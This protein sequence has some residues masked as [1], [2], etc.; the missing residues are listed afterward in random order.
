[1][2]QYF[3]RI[4]TLAVILCYT[5]FSLHAAQ[6]SDINPKLLIDPANNQFNLYINNQTGKTLYCAITTSPKATQSLATVVINNKESSNPITLTKAK[7]LARISKTT[8][9]VA[10]LDEHFIVEKQSNTIDPNVKLFSTKLP[11][12]LSTNCAGTLFIT[13]QKTYHEGLSF[14]IDDSHVQCGSFSATRKKLRSVKSADTLNKPIAPPTNQ[15]VQEAAQKE[16]NKVAQKAVQQA[17]QKREKF[18]ALER[19]VN[20]PTKYSVA[21]RRVMKVLKLPVW[22][23]YED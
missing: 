12:Y 20:D 14:S 19:D 15:E 17:K 13:V 8:S 7:G 3:S 22:N 18:K 6:K 1:M 16:G 2:K 5:M 11:Q 9:I 21:E 4:Y 23:V 10:S